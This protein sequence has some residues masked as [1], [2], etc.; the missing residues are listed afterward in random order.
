MALLPDEVDTSEGSKLKEV[1]AHSRVQAVLSVFADGEE[2]S[3]EK[4][5]EFAE[6]IDAAFPAGTEKE[7]GKGKGTEKEEQAA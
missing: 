5:S 6:A 2:L 4:L 7:Q 3:K 1:V